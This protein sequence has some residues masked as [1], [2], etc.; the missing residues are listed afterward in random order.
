M[1][2]DEVRDLIIESMNYAAY[3]ETDSSLYDADKNRLFASE[4]YKSGRMIVKP[5]PWVEGDFE[6]KMRTLPRLANI[7][8]RSVPACKEASTL[9]ENEN[10]VLGNGLRRRK[11]AGLA[12]MAR[13]IDREL[14]RRVCFSLGC[15]VPRDNSSSSGSACSDARG[16]FS[17]ATN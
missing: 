13:F 7:L 10:S 5:N 16:T 14:S 6:A 9:F 8:N 12:A 2:S 3:K 11:T 1:T 4:R 17:L 15:G